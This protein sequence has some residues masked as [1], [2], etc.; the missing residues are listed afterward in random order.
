MKFTPDDPV[1]TAYLLG[2]LN[3]SDSLSVASALEQ[4]ESLRR[5]HEAMSSLADLL[6][7]TLGKESLS[8]GP[9]RIAEIH[10][11]GQ[12]PNSDV[13]VLEHRKRS[14]R[15]SFWV[16]AGVAAVVVSGFV[17]LSRLDVGPSGG[18]G[19]TESG[20]S[21]SGSGSGGIEGSTRAGSS[22]VLPGEIKPS[23]KEGV[24]L[25][26][27]VSVGDPLFVAKA[28]HSTGTLPAREHFQIADWV[29]IGRV[30]LEPQLKVGNVG[31][32]VE[33]GPCSWN[34]DQTLLMV[35]LRPLDGR[36][37]SMDADL[38]FDPERVKSA[39]LL[40]GAGES[41]Q[42]VAQE[43]VLD[44]SQTLLYELELLETEERIGV[45]NLETLEGESGYLPITG[46]SHVVTALSREFRTAT[47]LGGFARWAASESRDMQ[48]LESLASEARSLMESVTDEPRRYAL[49]MILQSEDI[50]TLKNGE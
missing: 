32:Y 7:E 30:G 46:S 9:I 23:S 47:V 12:R 29:N 2:E 14:R 16:V 39:K 18:G 45:L 1:L 42:E 11:A 22:T 3:E 41:N 31:V 13:L 37:I 33:V 44:S 25:P 4:N 19:I 10:K 5:E 35:N 24:Q 21:G 27:N 8:L 28:L 6:S 36:K 34:R 17:A 38:T 15:Q 50:L 49:D 43:G 20:G 40:G 48:E 26:L